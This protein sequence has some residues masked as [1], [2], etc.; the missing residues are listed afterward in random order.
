[1]SSL[2]PSFP[3]SLP[4][5]WRKNKSLHGLSIRTLVVELVS[6]VGP[7]SLPPFFAK[8]GVLAD[9]VLR[10]SLPP[11][12]PSSLPV[13]HHPPLPLR[14]RLLPPHHPPLC[15]WCARPNLESAKGNRR[16][17][18]TVRREGGREGGREGSFFPHHPS[19]C[20]RRAR[21]GMESAKI[22]RSLFPTVGKEEGRGGGR[23]G[24]RATYSHII[25]PLFHDL[26]A[27]KAFGLS[28]YTR[29]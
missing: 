25:F 5:F 22:N 6:Q 26:T 1:M 11:S 2:P 29:A 24:R 3:P 7:P 14:R 19:I 18:S 16:I 20:F 9:E 21:P 12:L 15:H 10:S 13:E 23:E 4:S 27:A 28:W 17:L 8:N